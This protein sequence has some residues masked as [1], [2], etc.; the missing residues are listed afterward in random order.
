MSESIK[1]TVKQE[2]I[3]T[4]TGGF[5]QLGNI[6][7]PVTNWT[8]TIIED[9]NVVEGTITVVESKEEDNESKVA[10]TK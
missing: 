7:L 8:M 9:T 10:Y 1:K 6:T 2:R 3:I 4:T 5:I